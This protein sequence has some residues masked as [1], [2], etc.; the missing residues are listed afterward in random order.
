MHETKWLAAAQGDGPCFI[1]QEHVNIPRRFH[2]APR[3]A[4]TLR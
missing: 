1:E 3:M 2:G 4:I